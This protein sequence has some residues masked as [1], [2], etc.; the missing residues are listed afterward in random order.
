MSNDNSSG[1]GNDGK[2][3]NRISSGGM[4]Q[5]TRDDLVKSIEAARDAAASASTAAEAA[6]TSAEVALAAIDSGQISEGVG[7]GQ[8]DRGQQGPRQEEQDEDQ[9][10]HRA[11]PSD[12]DTNLANHNNRHPVGDGGRLGLPE[13]MARLQGVLKQVGKRVSVS[14]NASFMKLESQVNGH[15][16]YLSKGKTVVGRVESTLG[17]DQVNG[18]VAAERP[19][20]RIQSWIPADVNAVAEGIR[21]LASDKTEPV[22]PPL[23]GGVAGSGGGGQQDTQHGAGSNTSGRRGRLLN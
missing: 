15:K 1:N 11:A 6:A 21:R 12:G 10:E 14:E 16:I 18:A 13:F 17:V 2:N 3:R 22:R 19:N 23:R 9:P 4:K 7:G 20:G 5:I 8:S